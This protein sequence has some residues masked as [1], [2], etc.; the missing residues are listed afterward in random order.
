MSVDARSDRSSRSALCARCVLAKGGLVYDPCEVN[1]SSVVT[2][3][4]CGRAMAVDSLSRSESIL[5]VVRVSLIIQCCLAI[6]IGLI[7]SEASLIV[8]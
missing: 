7:S 2:S 3:T 5:A 6:N 4:S 8:G 1:R